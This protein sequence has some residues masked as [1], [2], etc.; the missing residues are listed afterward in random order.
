VAALHGS[1]FAT[2]LRLFWKVTV[3]IPTNKKFLEV[4]KFGPTDVDTVTVTYKS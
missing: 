3:L 2:K 4:F 1:R